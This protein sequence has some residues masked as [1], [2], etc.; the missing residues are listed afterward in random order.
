[1]RTTD[2]TILNAQQAMERASLA[3]LR[4]MGPADYALDASWWKDIKEFIG[5]MVRERPSYAKVYVP[6]CAAWVEFRDG[7]AELRVT[8]GLMH[9]DFCFVR[10]VLAELLGFIPQAGESGGR[11]GQA[12]TFWFTWKDSK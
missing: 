11:D 7:R 2:L 12:I 10:D 3:P 1:M 5:Q 4:S 9:N 8:G 6:G